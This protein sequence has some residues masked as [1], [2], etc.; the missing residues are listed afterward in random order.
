MTL[1]E[2]ITAALA[3]DKPHVPGWIAKPAR[4]LLPLVIAELERL[5]HLATGLRS[6]W[7]RTSK[8]WDE[9]RADLAEMDADLL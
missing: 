7:T 5:E 1:R 9:C 2:R 3:D 6:E 8:A 4:E